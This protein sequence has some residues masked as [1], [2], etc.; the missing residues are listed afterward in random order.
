VP[1][2]DP[3]I[4]EDGE[5]MLDD[6]GLRWRY[7][8]YT[9][10]DWTYSLV[11]E[12]KRLKQLNYMAKRPFRSN[13]RWN[14]IEK[15]YHMYHYKI[16]KYVDTWQGWIVLTGVGICSAVIATLLDIS[17][18]RLETW[19]TGY[20]QSGWYETKS[21]C[22][23]FVEWNETLGYGGVALWVLSAVLLA[24]IA[25]TIVESSSSH[26]ISAFVPSAR[27]TERRTFVKRHYH[28]SGSGIPETKTIL[29]GFVIRGFLGLRTLLTKSLALVFT[30]AS[31]FVVGVQGPLVH[32]C[33]AI[34]NVTTRL[35]SKYRNNDAKR[36][37]ILSAACAGGVSV[38]F[39]APMGGVLFSLEEVSMY[40]P[41][42]TMWRSFYC[43]LVGSVTLKLLSGG[44][45]G[46]NSGALFQ[47]EF[48]TD[49]QWTEIPVFLFL[50][51]LGGLIGSSFIRIVN[52]VHRRKR[53]IKAYTRIDIS[54]RSLW[55]I[56]GSCHRFCWGM[57][58]IRERLF[59]PFQHQTSQR[60][61]PRVQ[62]LEWY[63]T[64]TSS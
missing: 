42:K 4:V 47:V 63:Y 50:G 23:V 22:K 20:C 62:Q 37:E 7:D 5:V 36:R 64:R 48:D 34:G 27:D 25:T 10:I 57:V 41:P 56:R 53:S 24:L 44:N 28:A 40:F 17:I 54:C 38:A 26:D 49:W 1:T 18:P 58:R 3:V 59:V 60:A 51:V 21:T 29:S 46:E 16:L 6:H 55:K 12:R 30:I 2:E 52:W 35:F 43:A 45:K 19:R 32:I 8:N 61:S 31:G 11:Q 13:Q 39:G 9:T 33:C 15:L 14:A